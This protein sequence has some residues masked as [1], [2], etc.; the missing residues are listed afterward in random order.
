MT[1]SE[2]NFYN[3]YDYVTYEFKDNTLHVYWDSSNKI[4]TNLLYFDLSMYIIIE[5]EKVEY[6]GYWADKLKEYAG[7]NEG[8]IIYFTIKRIRSGHFKIDICDMNSILN[9]GKID[10]DGYLYLPFYERCYGLTRGL[11]TKCNCFYNKFLDECEPYI[12]K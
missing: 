4:I 5:Y 2:I 6:N 12:L 10:K 7:W 8:D 9:T 1:T 3:V 11:L